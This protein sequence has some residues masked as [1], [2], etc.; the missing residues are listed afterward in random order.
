M[1][2]PRIKSTLGPYLERTT[3][4]PILDAIHQRIEEAYRQETDELE[5]CL[6]NIIA[7]GVPPSCIQV[8]RVSKWD[9]FT[10]HFYFDIAFHPGPNILYGS[11]IL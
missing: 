8:F 2:P 9:G 3:P 1:I 10:V 11:T 5:A 6:E 7:A 4:T